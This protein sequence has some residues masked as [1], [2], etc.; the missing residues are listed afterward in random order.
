ME[1]VL[2]QFSNDILWMEGVGCVLKG[3]Q[4]FLGFEVRKKRDI[5]FL[6]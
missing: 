4:E 5:V 1:R 3:T 2:L 6:G